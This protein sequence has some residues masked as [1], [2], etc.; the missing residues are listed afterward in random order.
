MSDSFLRDCALV[1]VSKNAEP[2]FVQDGDRIIARL[3]GY[4]VIPRA[5]FDAMGGMG[6]SAVA[7][8]RQQERVTTIGSATVCRNEPEAE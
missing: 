7:A 6:H 1:P 5:V 2:M 8:H 4:A 3:E